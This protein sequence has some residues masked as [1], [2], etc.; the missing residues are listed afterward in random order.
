MNRNSI[1]GSLYFLEITVLYDGK[2][3]AVN[4]TILV[5][6]DAYKS[7]YFKIGKGCR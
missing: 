1:L 4:S 6:R 2:G 5:K 7:S 3:K